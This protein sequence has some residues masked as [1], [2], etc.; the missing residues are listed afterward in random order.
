MCW[1]LSIMGSDKL[2]LVFLKWIV[3]RLRHFLIGI[4]LYIEVM[5]KL[6]IV[7]FCISMFLISLSKYP[8]ILT[9]EELIMP[10]TWG[11]YYRYGT[12]YFVSGTT[13]AGNNG[14][15]R[16]LWILVS[17]W[18]I[19]Y[20]TIFLILSDLPKSAT[21]PYIYIYICTY[22][23]RR[24]IHIHV[25]MCTHIYTYLYMHMHIHIQKYTYICIYVRTL[26]KWLECSPMARETWV[27]SQVES[28]QRLKKWYLMPPCLTLSIIRY[29]SRVK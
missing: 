29:G 24:H 28:Y 8:E 11:W 25:H 18:F 9:C 15:L 4:F 23:Q 5:S 2:N 19:H 3:R 27:Q 14:S 12:S 1:Q 26:A 16:G 13:N 17:V 22:I 21:S 7:L 10:R 6:F 20:S